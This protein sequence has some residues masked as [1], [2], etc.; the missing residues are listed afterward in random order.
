MGEQ[1]DGSRI[2][3]VLCAVPVDFDA[4]GLAARLVESS[5]AACV[6]IGTAIR[7]VYC[8]KGVVE[9]SDE[10]LVLIKTTRERYRELESAIRAGHPYDVPEIV[11]LEAIDGF[12]G[13]LT[14]VRTE[15]VGASR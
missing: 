12:E 10:R 8:W 2:L 3:V 6:Q 11:A 4:D 7:S 5:L 9:R 15:T 1:L 14:W 13:Y